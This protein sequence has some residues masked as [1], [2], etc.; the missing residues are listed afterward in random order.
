MTK[1]LKHDKLFKRIMSN[2][3]AAKEFLEYYLPSNFKEKVDLSK[4]TIEKESYIEETLQEKFSDI[5]YSIK[6]NNDDTAFV[7]IL[8]D[9]QSTVDYWMALRL[10]RYALPAIPNMS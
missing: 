4:I 2:K 5:V 1:K 8:L 10:W 7:Y 3:I 6:T 9:H